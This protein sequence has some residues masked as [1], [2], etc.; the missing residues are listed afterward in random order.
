MTPRHSW[1]RTGRLDGSRAGSKAVRVYVCEG[2]GLWH[3]GK[4]PAQCMACGRMDFEHFDSTGE[5]K[6]YASLQL[7]QR[8][9]MITDLRRQVDLDLLTMGP[10]GMPVVWGKMRVDYAFKENGVQKYRD[11]KPLAGISPDAALKIRCLAAQ[12]VTVEIYNSKGNV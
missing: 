3:Q 10:K 1:N 9:G 7:Q 11:W 8:E 5:A 2:C 12:G 4:K 6:H